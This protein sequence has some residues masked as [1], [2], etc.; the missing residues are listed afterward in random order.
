M[1]KRA[2]ASAPLIRVTDAK[3]RAGRVAQIVGPQKTG[4]TF[5]TYGGYA[6]MKR[7]AKVVALVSY[8]RPAHP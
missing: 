4:F 3:T 8:P 7:K 6:E 5:S 2:A 1:A